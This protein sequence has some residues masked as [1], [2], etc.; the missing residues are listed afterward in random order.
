M[1]DEGHSPDYFDKARTVA[2]AG[3]IVAALLAI[4]GSLLDWVHI[5]PPNILPPGEAPN[6]EPFTGVEA[7]DGLW[8]ISGALILLA[9]GVGLLLRRRGAYALLAF[10][11]SVVIGAIAVADY[12]GL[13]EVSSAIS[14]RMNI[15]G[16][17]SAGIGLKLVAVSAL[18]GLISSVIG[19]AATPKRTS[20]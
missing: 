7:Q 9:C 1:E 6:V 20:D 13:G 18:I 12:R 3:L 4:L 19:L 17:A 11:I 8:V 10:V 2:V 14:R 5:T 15:V 16:D